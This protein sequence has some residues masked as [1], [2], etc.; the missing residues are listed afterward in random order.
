M[1][2]TYLFLCLAFTFGISVV[3]SGQ[4]APDP[5]TLKHQWTFDDG[6]AK[7]GVG[8]LDGTLMD[9]AKISNYALNTTNG[10]WVNFDA[11]ALAINTYSSITT[12][13][14]FTA[15]KGNGD[16]TMLTCYGNTGNGGGGENYLCTNPTH[17]GAG[18]SRTSITT[19][20][21]DN[22]SGDE[23][24][25]N[26][27]RC[28]DGKL[29]QLISI[30][31]GPNMTISLYIDGV[32]YGTTTL[33]HNNAI[34]GL[35]T[36]YFYLAKSDWN[37]D[38][39]WKGLMEKVSIY[40]AALTADEVLYLFNQGAETQK[41]I[42]VGAPYLL[43]DSQNADIT[44]T[45]TGENLSSNSPILM[46]L[47]AGITAQYNN[48]FV[49]SLPYNSFNENVTFIYDGKTTV[50]G[51]IVFTSGT[52]TNI[53]PVKAIASSTCFV[54]LYSS[55]QITNIVPDP[56]MNAWIPGTDPKLPITKAGW[57]VVKFAN[58]FTDPTHIYCGASTLQL[59]DSTTAG[60]SFEFHPGVQGDIN[61]GVLA[62]SYTYRVKF[63]AKTTN[64]PFQL[65]I[66][67]ADLDNPA[68]NSIHKT[69]DTG[70]EWKEVNFYFITGARL[71][72][73]P[74]IFLND[75]GLTGKLAYFD[76][77]EIY[78]TTDP[79]IIP[80]VSSVAFDP[81][82][83]S[84]SMS[85]SS[86]NLLN[87]ITVTVPAGIT[88]DQP[89][90]YANLASDVLNVTWDGTTAV[91]GNITLTSG[92]TTVAIPVKTTSSTNASC[93]TP[94]YSDRPNLIPDPFLNDK[95]KFNGWVHNAIGSWGM[96]DIATNPDSV[97]C[98]SH[99]VKLYSSA[100]IELP[101]GGMLTESS[102]YVARVMVRTIGGF[103][104]MGIN[105]IDTSIP[106]DIVDSIDTEGA[107][108]Q[109]TFKFNTGATMGDPVIF[110][111]NYKNN[112]RVAYLDNWEL[113]QLDE[114]NAAVA[115]VK[116]L[117]EKLYIQNG[118]IV[119][120]FV[121]DQ[122]TNVQLTVYTV[123]GSM[124]SN[125]KIAGTTG[126]NHKTVEA[127]LPSGVYMVKITKDGTSSF[128]KLIK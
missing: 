3:A 24:G 45:V 119:A 9:G 116:D 63:M 101:L 11:A 79:F 50:S 43:L 57:G 121:L 118:K 87:D 74:V 71:D 98:G 115:P 54:P 81:D 88:V 21:P 80:T 34:S 39:K 40:D 95:S 123:T 6:T 83:K 51:N 23:S 70:G 91:S 33:T 14:W 103:F 120:D 109:M 32:S 59:G 22:W 125:E 15:A 100:D 72:P 19:N 31:D 127:I 27:P 41:T 53:L 5:A 82:Y 7:D 78:P 17:N 52:T 18:G 55:D 58:L 12:E 65:N 86:V 64:G 124:V 28:D 68:N 44:T 111:N 84:S 97:Y 126:L 30:V 25:V 90:M 4:T 94:L 104:H 60:G 10:G 122:S 85:V 92:A 26:G 20:N 108:K 112:G 105:R 47:P 67:G 2:K 61:N 46:T 16:F 107:W 66:V 48:K 110:F 75:D 93:F 36:Q 96:I 38:P 62:P 76:N 89:V 49:T 8:T 35:G 69:F 37:A 73:N 1:K 114:L 106:E 128:R 113:Y 117:F 99:S 56:G 102:G 29:H 13:V 42:S 77:L